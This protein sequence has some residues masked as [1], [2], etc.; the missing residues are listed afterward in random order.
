MK[1]NV[2]ILLLVALTAG[3]IAFCVAN[4]V[5]CRQNDRLPAD[6]LHNRAFL[7]KTLHL[8]DEQQQALDALESALEKRV[9]E[10][11][12][13][14]CA[15]RRRLASALTESTTDQKVLDEIIMDMCRAYEDSERT[16]LEHILAVRRILDDR[17]RAEFDIMMGRCLCGS[18]GESCNA[19]QR[20]RRPDTRSAAGPASRMLDKA[21]K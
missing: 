18:C 6:V 5:V 17:Q 3:V 2:M 15:A 1:C 4:C 7:A 8:T 16:A 9:N 21:E 14:H 12:S 19:A 11:C 20:C 13:K 10:G